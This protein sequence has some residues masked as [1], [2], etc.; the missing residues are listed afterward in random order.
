MTF[1]A[2][3]R[4][5]FLLYNLDG[6]GLSTIQMIEP[7][8]FALRLDISAACYMILPIFLVW[9]VGLFIPL[10]DLRKIMKIY[11]WIIVPLMAFVTVVNLEIFKEWNHQV[12]RDVFD[13]LKYP[14]ETLASTRN[15]PWIL[16]L[17]LSGLICFV[18]LRWGL[19]ILEMNW[20]FSRVASGF[21]VRKVG[22]SLVK[23]LAAFLIFAI[24]ARGGTQ[25]SPINQSFVLYSSNPTL[26]AA[27]VNTA[28]NLF[29]SYSINERKNPYTF[30]NKDEVVEILKAI[31]TDQTNAPK[32]F[33]TEKPN[34]VLVVLEG[35]V[36]E[37]FSKMGGQNNLTPNMDRLIDSSLLFDKIYAT[38]K[39]TDRG[40]V[41]IL[42]GYPSLPGLSIVKQPHRSG[43]LPFLPKQLRGVGYGTTFIYGGESEFANIKSYLMR[44]GFNRIID[45]NDFNAKDMNSKWGAHD[46]IVF[47]RTLL[48]LEKME[49]P[50]FTTILTLSSHEP[51]DIPIEGAYQGNDRQTL[52]KNSIIYLDKAVGSFLEKAGREPYIDNTIFVFISDHGFRVGDAINWYPR[53]HRIPLFIYGIPLKNEWRGKTISQI[54]SQTDLAKTILNQFALNSDEFTFSKDLM[55]GNEGFAFY[56]FNE[57]FGWIDKNQKVVYDHQLKTV[58]FLNDTT[59]H[60]LNEP[61]F[62][63]GKAYL[64]NS[65]RDFIDRE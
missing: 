10:H 27:T 25:L 49:Q 15:S 20:D 55:T 9:L 8:W 59:S 26:N 56:T 1:F 44:A 3:D 6:E 42:S 60:N 2:T 48:E 23:C 24:G 63:L 32:I 7:F 62:K 22:M 39:R 38:E 19:K 13:Y 54:G 29:Y 64:Q 35:A 34:I 40:L 16:L 31:E 12:N 11:F 45:K 28:W 52:Y 30:F 50:F 61:L 41:S 5:L 37:L 43:T 14:Q 4:L 51:F 47:D 36:A 58:T 17:S 65:F 53:R 46:H 18:Y 33:S 21:N 57:G